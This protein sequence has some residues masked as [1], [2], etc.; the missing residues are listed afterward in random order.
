M[1]GSIYFLNFLSSIFA[2]MFSRLHSMLPR[3][4]IQSVFN[5]ND[6]KWYDPCIFNFDLVIYQLRQKVTNNLMLLHQLCQTNHFLY[7]TVMSCIHDLL[8]LM[9]LADVR[10]SNFSP[11]ISLCHIYA[12]HFL[13]K[14]FMCI[15]ISFF[16]LILQNFQYVL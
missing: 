8:Q 10:V 7:V 15:S 13:C 14:I 5:Y 4:S 6:I 11:F 1:Y 9:N 2:T 16:F 3:M 12:F